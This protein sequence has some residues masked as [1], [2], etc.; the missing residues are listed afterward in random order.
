MTEVFTWADYKKPAASV[1]PNGAKRPTPKLQDRPEPCAIRTIAQ[2]QDAHL[3]HVTDIVCEVFKSLLRTMPHDQAEDILH[4]SVDLG[5]AKAMR[6][7]S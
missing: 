3:R 2:N 6:E 7:P 5:F 4:R 1:N